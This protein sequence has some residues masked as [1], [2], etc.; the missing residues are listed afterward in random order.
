MPGDSPLADYR[1][2]ISSALNTGEKYLADPSWIKSG[3]WQDFKNDLGELKSKIKDDYEMAAATTWLGK[4]LPFSPFEISKIIPRTKNTGAKNVS[5]FRELNPKTVLFDA[6]S[7][8]ATKTAFDSIAD[9]IG[10]KGYETLILDF[11]GRSSIN[12]A[13]ANYFANFISKRIFTAGV[14]LTRKWFDSNLKIPEANQYEKLFKSFAETGYKVNSFT[15][16]KGRT[17]KIVPSQNSFKGKVFVLTDSKTSKVSE[18]LVHILK[19]EKIAVI[20]GQKTNGSAFLVER[21]PVTGEFELIFPVAEFYPANGKP[22][23]KNGIEPNKPVSKEDILQY[24][25]KNLIK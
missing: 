14:F 15:T 18:V 9:I 19:T 3:N 21:L 12:P 16:E 22:V 11:R 8:P 13:A 1:T 2:I 23:E 24:V 17:L 6:N 10:K 7:V 25:L 5:S 20:V 4:K